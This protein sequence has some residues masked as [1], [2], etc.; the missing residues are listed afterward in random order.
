MEINHLKNM[1]QLTFIKRSHLTILNA[2]L[3]INVKILKC[4]K[5]IVK[6]TILIICYGL[7]LS[8]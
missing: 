6:K 7:R 4:S 5:K 3:Q 1:S 8:Q 2:S